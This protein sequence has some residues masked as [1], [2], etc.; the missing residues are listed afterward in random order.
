[1]PFS[2]QLGIVRYPPDTLFLLFL[3]VV[4]GVAQLVS[5]GE[6]LS[7]LPKWVSIGW[8]VIL[9]TGSLTS[10]IGIFWK[11]R[12]VGFQIEEAGRHMLWATCFAYALFLVGYG[13]FGMSP[14]LVL[15]FGVTC[16]FRAIYLKKIYDDWQ[17]LMKYDSTG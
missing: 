11:D 14:I 12:P 6:L 8:S 17:E 1:M 5:P 2:K 13:K 3:C 9:T 16:L 7:T 15:A 4:S 10:L